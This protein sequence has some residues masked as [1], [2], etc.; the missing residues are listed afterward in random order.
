MHCFLFFGQS[1]GCIPLLDASKN[2]PRGE[3]TLTTLKRFNEYLGEN[4]IRSS[5][6]GI[7]PGVVLLTVPAIL[8]DIASLGLEAI[9]ALADGTRA[10]TYGGA[11]LPL[12]IGDTLTENGI[13]LISDLGM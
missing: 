4:I 5:R 11:P 3:T 1:C 7:V 2:L 8:S 12:E 9:K 6:F 13:D 10:V